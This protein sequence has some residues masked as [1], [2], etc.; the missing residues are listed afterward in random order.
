MNS[1][2]G[3]EFGS[4]YVVGNEDYK[5]NVYQGWDDQRW[6][7]PYAYDQSS[8]QQPPPMHYEE[9][10]FYDAYQPNGYGESPC[11]F[12]EPPPYTYESYPQHEPQPYSQASFHQTP[13]YDLDSFPPYQPPFEPYEPYMEPPFQYQYSQ[14]PP[15]YTPPL[16]YQEEPPSYYEPF[17]QDNEPSY[18]PQSSMDEILSLI[19]QGQGEMQRETLEFVATLTKVVSTLA[20][21]YLSTQSTPTVTCGE[22]IEKHKER[23]ETPVEIEGCYF[24]LEQLEEPM[25]I[26]EEEEVVEDL[27]DAE[28]PWKPR[29]EKN[30]S[31]KSEFDVEEECAQPPRHIPYED[32]EEMEQKLS[33][34]GDEDH[35]S[36]L[37]GG[38]S[39]EFEEPSP[40]EIESDVEV[41]FSQPPIYDLSDGEELDEIDEQRIGSEEAYEEV[42]VVKEEHKGVELVRT[43]E[44]P[45]PKPPPSIISFKYFL[46]EIEGL[47]QK[48]DSEVEEGLLMLLD[49]D[50]PA[51]KMDFLEL[52]NSK[53]RDFNCI[54]K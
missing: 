35:A 39:F 7:E 47:E 36:N 31:K 1:H 51:L 25:I 38:E 32:L 26:E 17:F 5:E 8:W 30:L 40:N 41:D 9:E 54:G 44:I 29:V 3:Y 16:S 20:S 28:P 43:L 52:Q 4:H 24:V 10:P 22:S 48:S 6:E 21:Q 49:S 53:W 14:E 19:L 12:Q 2:F 11:D 13:P 46:A 23:L 15:Q 50:L 18:P 42:E 37:L 27:G 34:L 33:S 45:L